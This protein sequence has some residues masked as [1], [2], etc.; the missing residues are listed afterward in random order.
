MKEANVVIII[1]HEKINLITNESYIYSES[2]FVPWDGSDYYYSMSLDSSLYNYTI[3]AS[4]DGY[5]SQ[6]YSGN[7]LVKPSEGDVVEPVQDVTG[8][9]FVDTQNQDEGVPEESLKAAMPLLDEGGYSEIFV[10]FILFG[11]MCI[12]VAIIV[13]LLFRNVKK[14]E[15]KMKFLMML[16]TS[17]DSELMNFWGDFR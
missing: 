17:G 12:E 2:Y 4:R 14:E 15:E 9:Y 6:K 16:M 11:F 5:Q 1:S 8:Q 13:F 3:T 10:V 7:V